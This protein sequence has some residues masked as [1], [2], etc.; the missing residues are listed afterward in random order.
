MPP[1]RPCDGPSNLGKIHAVC[2]R[3]RRLG[4]AHSLCTE[5]EGSRARECHSEGTPRTRRARSEA[6]GR[7]PLPA[8]PRTSTSVPGSFCKAGLFRD[9]GGRTCLRALGYDSSLPV[10]WKAPAGVLGKAAI[11]VASKRHRP[12]EL[13]FSIAPTPSHRGVH[14]LG[15]SEPGPLTAARTPARWPHVKTR[16]RPP[17]C[18]QTPKPASSRLFTDLRRALYLASSWR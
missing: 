7:R 5:R 4:C 2:T 9:N 15:A 17:L 14:R 1:C 13:Q 3:K 10:A 12:E 18:P 16:S 11:V 6:G 8:P